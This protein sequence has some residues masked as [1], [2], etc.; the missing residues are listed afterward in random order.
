MSDSFQ[1]FDLGYTPSS[2]Q[3]LTVELVPQSAWGV[4]LRSELSQ[5]DWDKLR[6]MT[7][8]DA[9]YH[10]EVCGGQG[11]NH[12]VECHE[13]WEYDDE[14]HIQKLLGLIALCPDCHEVKHFG[15][16]QKV[17]REKQAIAHMMKV[18]D[19]TKGQTI[20]HIRKAA[21]LWKERSLHKWILDLLWLETVGVSIP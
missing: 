5:E 15:R 20:S 3:I 4:N 1:M 13:V 16:T 8:E 21:K 10:C 11:P 12:P 14:K 7:Y 2:T 9:A 19:W 17:G 6:K 18:N